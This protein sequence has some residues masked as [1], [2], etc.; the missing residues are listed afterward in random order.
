MRQIFPDLWQTR[1]EYPIAAAPEIATHA[2]LLKTPKRNVLLYST[3]HDGEIAAISEQGGIS[4][5]L[6]SHRDEVGPALV[7]IRER[8]GAKL[9]CHELE[10]DAVRGVA[11]VD[12][13]LSGEES[14]VAGLTA[15]LTPGHTGGSVCYV[16]DSPSGKR[17]LFTGDTVFWGGDGWTAVAFPAE[18]G[19]VHA[20][21]ASLM[22]L[23][24]LEPDVVISSASSGAYPFKLMGPG[25]W[26]AALDEAARRLEKAA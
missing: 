9:V 24:A 4:H 12:I 14:T 5:Q 23:K 1:S 21:T 17:Y 26:H 25:E 2:Y 7:Q 16:Y 19:G 10:V 15:I 6:L 13:A 22:K 20:L 18:G 3:G 11:P 8:L